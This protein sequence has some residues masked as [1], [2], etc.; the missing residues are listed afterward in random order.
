[1]AKTK[2]ALVY[3]QDLLNKCIEKDEAVL[4]GTYEKLAQNID[5]K[6]R[7]KCGKDG[8][9][10]F[11]NIV[12]AAGMKCKECSLIASANKLKQTC[13]EKYGVDN[14]KK[15]EESKIKASKRCKVYTIAKLVELVGNNLI[16]EY[17]Q[18]TLTRETN[19]KFHCCKCSVIH[20]KSFLSILKWSG[21]LCKECSMEQMVVRYKQTMISKY[22][23]DNPLR[24]PDIK[25]KIRTNNLLYT[26]DRLKEVVGEYIIGEYDKDTIN[27]KTI[28]KFRC[29]ECNESHEKQFITLCEGG[30]VFCRICTENNRLAQN[31]QNCLSKYGV[32]NYMKVPEIKSKVREKLVTFTLDRLKQVVGDNLIGE[33]DKDTLNRETII[34]FYCICCDKVY[35]KTFRMIEEGGGLLCKVCCDAGK[36]E[37]IRQS[38]KSQHGVE[39]SL[40]V[41]EFNDK[42]TYKGLKYKEYVG[43]S[44]KKY[45]CQGYEPY[46]L[47]LLFIEYTDDDVVTSKRDVPDI[48]WI[49]ADGLQHRYYV[50]IYIPKEKRM[51]EVKSDYR[52]KEDKDKLEFVW[53]TCVEQGYTYEVW[54]F[55]KHHEIVEFKVYSSSSLNGS[56]ST[57]SKVSSSSSDK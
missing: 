37:K 44:G 21:A 12:L 24:L 55:D 22:E 39:Y 48:W 6:F 56:T 30:G 14:Y 18:E 26:I 3:N 31:K 29:K 25:D 42:A 23:V 9:K 50:D 45:N 17:K 57:S 38:L 4:V 53:R 36:Y 54:I 40:Q 41:P 52:Y 1:M 34:N 10:T 35:E 28:I 11:K 7:C 47:D 33:Y 2:Q 13:L 15:T 49:D 46:A 27:G 20:E 16:G 51:I 32:D 8:N 43:P 5:I 19:I